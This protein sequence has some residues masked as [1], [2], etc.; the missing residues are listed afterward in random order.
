MNARGTA[1]V[2]RE[3][4]TG[5]EREMKRMQCCL[6]EVSE[7]SLIGH[8]GHRGSILLPVCRF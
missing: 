5:G 8:E 2:Q 3:N 4:E 6:R 7:S 1:E